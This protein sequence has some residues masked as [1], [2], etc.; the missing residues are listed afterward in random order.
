MSSA[1][2]AASANR[3]VF[4]RARVDGSASLS[5]FVVPTDIG[6]LISGLQ[7]LRVD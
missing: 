3:K 5:V 2:K 7:I 1:P 4:A 6:Q